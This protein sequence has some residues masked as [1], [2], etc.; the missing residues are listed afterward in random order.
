[1]ETSEGDMEPTACIVYTWLEKR[2]FFSLKLHQC[3]EHD[4]A[5]VNKAY[6][7]NRDASYEAGGEY[8]I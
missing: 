3:N 7:F 6:T 1:M 4:A 5:M 8:K 2:C